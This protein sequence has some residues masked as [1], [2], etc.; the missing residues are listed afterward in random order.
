VKNWAEAT[1]KLYKKGCLSGQFYSLL[2]LFSIFFLTE[3][4]KKKPI[5]TSDS[6]KSQVKHSFLP[7]IFV[8]MRALPG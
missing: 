5:F 4:R 2:W 6:H 3:N 8:C 7:T 1:H